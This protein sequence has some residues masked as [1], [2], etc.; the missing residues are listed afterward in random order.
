MVAIAALSVSNGADAELLKRVQVEQ[1]GD[2]LLIGNT[3]GFDCYHQLPT[4][5]SSTFTCPTLP[6]DEAPDIFWRADD[7]T[8]VA[9]NTITAATARTTAVLELPASATVTHAYLY[10]AA[11]NISSDP[12]SSVTI[13][14]PGVN[15]FAPQTIVAT[16]SYPATN[17]DAYQSVAD[18]TALVRQY[19]NG[20]YRIGDIAMMPFLGDSSSLAFGAWALVVLYTEPNAGLRNLAV[21]DGLDY[22]A[23]G[24]PPQVSSTTVDG[25]VAPNSDLEGKI[26]VVAY[27]GDSPADGDQLFFKFEGDASPTPV[28]DAHNEATNFF[29]STRSWLGQLESNVGDLP[30][31]SG[32]IQTMAGVDL[33]VVDISA[34]LNPGQTAAVVEAKSVQSA[35]VLG[36]VDKFFLGAFVT[37][38]D[39]YRPD[40]S[41][42]TKEVV[43]LDGGSVL[44]GD[45]LDYTLTFRNTGNDDA[46]NATARDTLP[47]GITYAAG[48]LSIDGP[49]NGSYDAATRVLSLRLGTGATTTSGGTVA[50][51]QTIKATIRVQVDSNTTGTVSNQAFIVASGKHG[52][53]V[54]ET[55][56][57][58]NGTSVVGAP[59]TDVFVHG[60]DDNR[61]CVAPKPVCDTT[62]SPRVCVGCLLDADCGSAASGKI[63]E[64]KTCIDGCRATGGNGC[65]NDKVCTSTN[66]NPG[67]CVECL[68]NTDCDNGQICDVPTNTCKIGCIGTEPGR[69]PPN[70]VCTSK[71]ASVGICVEC[72]EDANCGSVVSGRICDPTVHTC[73]DGCRAIGGNGCPTP[74]ICTSV[75]ATAGTCV[76]CTRDADCGAQDSGKVCDAERRT[77]IE[78]CRGTDGNRCSAANLCTSTDAS[79]GSCYPGA[80]GA[81]GASGNAGQAGE[82]PILG[83]QGGLGGT[84]AT[85]GSSKRSATVNWD[86]VVAQGNGCACRV[87]SEPAG[88]STAWLVGFLLAL[89]T[90]LRRGQRRRD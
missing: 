35:S 33:D 77:C 67:T 88:R 46:I 60:C 42:S 89:G 19:G 4:P 8:A 9:D 27:K 16:S 84:S 21:F 61:H 86:E 65:A 52:S 17:G 20:A 26:G 11:K 72:V 3:M 40:F 80:A 63:C 23:D 36:T 75:D 70:L 78:G 62:V 48:T 54:V 24:V 22:V 2:F 32:A 50:A 53:P 69:C 90:S 76:G 55:P 6:D 10:W 31:I 1:R 51:G 58:G 82:A 45:F 83:G 12:D 47:A 71:D 57:D 59:P 87:A 64:A 56:T 68:K 18:V 44:A 25:F 28:S 73:R 15:G 34:K 30:Q 43:D 37:S 49:G 29:N 7:T 38:I 39:V 79:I 5:P 81:A 66:V 41:Q 14:R 13:E 74:L 85:G